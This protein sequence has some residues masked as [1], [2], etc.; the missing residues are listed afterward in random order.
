MSKYA[1]KRAGL[2]SDFLGAMIHALRFAE[3]Q[4]TGK[5]RVE[6]EKDVTVSDLKKSVRRVDT[7]CTRKPNKLNSKNL[8][9][10]QL[11]KA[12]SKPK[13]GKPGIGFDK[14]RK[15]SSVKSDVT[16]KVTKAEKTALRQELSKKTR[17]GATLKGAPRGISRDELL[18]TASGSGG[19][20]SKTSSLKKEPSVRAARQQSNET[21]NVGGNRASRRSRLHSHYVSACNMAGTTEN[22]FEKLGSGQKHRWEQAKVAVRKLKNASYQSVA[23]PATDSGLLKRGGSVYS[24]YTWTVDSKGL[25]LKVKRDYGK[26]ISGLDF[27]RMDGKNARIY[28]SEGTLKRRHQKLSKTKEIRAG[29]LADKQVQAMK[30]KLAV[31]SNDDPIEEM[32]SKHM[33]QPN[34]DEI[35]ALLKFGN[36]RL[37]ESDKRLV[38]YGTLRKGF[39][40]GRRVLLR[41]VTAKLNLEDRPKNVMSTEKWT[42]LDKD[43]YLRLRKQCMWLK[44]PTMNPKGKASDW[45]TVA[46]ANVSQDKSWREVVEQIEKF[47]STKYESM[48]RDQRNFLEDGVTPNSYLVSVK[49]PRLLNL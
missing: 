17:S 14:V 30:E 1:A 41:A 44:D 5:N 47:N 22:P 27:Q 45:A 39:A 49:D 43:V 9:K 42:L 6:R 21:L 20:K 46:R 23:L 37:D 11:G 26:A 48:K 10:S 12:E 3:K 25:P 16:P 40:Y 29:R 24:H 28:I 36:V 35:R 7:R 33:S 34:S 38:S 18:G 4:I 8:C 32:I 19:Q 31:V 2:S 13:K 15:P